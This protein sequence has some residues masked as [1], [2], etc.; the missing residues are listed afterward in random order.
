MRLIELRIQVVL[1][2]REGA[3]RCLFWTVMIEILSLWEPLCL[4]GSSHC[5]SVKPQEMFFPTPLDFR[6]GRTAIR[7]KGWGICENWQHLG[8]YSSQEAENTH[9]ND[10]VGASFAENR[11]GNVKSWSSY[12]TESQWLTGFSVEVGLPGVPEMGEPPGEKGYLIKIDPVLST[13]GSSVITANRARRSLIDL[14]ASYPS[15]CLTDSSPKHFL[16][17]T[18]SSWA[19]VVPGE[20]IILLPA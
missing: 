16:P 20:R 15:A 5:K 3:G 7:F 4:Y 17:W 13:F 18:W 11:E 8:P 12:G 10:Q 19:P 6:R 9:W 2:K 1:D 14:L